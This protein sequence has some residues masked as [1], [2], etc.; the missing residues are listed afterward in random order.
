[1]HSTPAIFVKHLTPEDKFLII[2][3]DGVWGQMTKDEALALV[4]KHSS[5]QEAS[6]ELASEARRRAKLKAMMKDYSNVEVDHVTALV[7]LFSSEPALEGS[8]VATPVKRCPGAASK[9]L[10]RAV[11][12]PMAIDVPSDVISSNFDLWMLS[13]EARVKASQ[14]VKELFKEMLVEEDEPSGAASFPSDARPPLP[15]PI[16]LEPTATT[17][18]R[19]PR[20]DPMSPEV[21]MR[22][23]PIRG[24]R[25]INTVQTGV[26]SDMYVYSM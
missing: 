11:G 4:Q 2:C 15:M 25:P 19:L 14:D 10:F 26:P 17:H 12:K 24:H 22:R 8:D 6:W 21:A 5:A 3:S 16:P 7:V 13:E 20:A 9:N 1:M 23:P 18:S